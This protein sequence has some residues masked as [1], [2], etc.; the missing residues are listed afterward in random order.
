MHAG[1]LLPIRFDA[2]VSVYLLSP[3][4]VRHI[5]PVVFIKTRSVFELLL[6]YVEDKIPF[7]PGFRGQRCPGNRKV[8]LAESQEAARAQD[9]IPD[10]SSYRVKH[11]VPNVTELFSLWVFHISPN[12]FGHAIHICSLV[13]GS[14]GYRGKQ[15]AAQGKHHSTGFHPFHGC[16]PSIHMSSTQATTAH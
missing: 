10:A 15:Q 9:G 13:L 3:A 8:L 7:F 16:S 2:V 4:T 1:F 11:D 5:W 14:K 12:K 6:I